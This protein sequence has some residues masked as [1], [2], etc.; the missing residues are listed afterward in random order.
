MAVVG[1]GGIVELNREWPAPT[2]VDKSRVVGTTSL[3]LDLINPEFW[4]GD[5]VYIVADRGVPF[6]T[7][8]DGF[9]NCPDG[10][11]FYPGSGNDEG[12]VLLART[13]GGSFYGNDDTKPFY[14]DISLRQQ[15]F[16][17]FIHRNSLDNVLFYSSEVDAINGGTTG[18]IPLR[19]VDFGKAIIA[20]SSPE[21][22]YRTFLLQQAALVLAVESQE[23]FVLEPLP[24]AIEA[25]VNDPSV[26]GW[27]QQGSLSQ[28]VFEMDAAQL[29]QGAIGEAFGEY[30]KGM[31]KGSGS[32][33]AL[34]SHDAVA[35]QSSSSNLLKLLTL[36]ARGAK[37]KAR[38]LMSS[39]EINKS[40]NPRADSL[41]YSTDILFWKTEVNATDN[42]LIRMTAEFIA[43]GAIQIIMGQEE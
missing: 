6:D 12:P 39:P 11:A 24:P 16:E 38:F 8:G 43:T 7:D 9:A 31:L 19:R 15:I 34:L 30:A 2:V 32:F 28:W 42:D 1:H 21:Q 41:Y 25:L 18:L 5:K 29:D 10:F 17:A 22:F 13:S 23:E 3:S 20:I 37:A 27:K 4:S 33:A 26:R 35:G 36:T 40:Q 14:E